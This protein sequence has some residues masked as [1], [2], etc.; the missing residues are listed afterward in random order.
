MARKPPYKHVSFDERPEFLAAVAKLDG[1]DQAEFP[2]LARAQVAKYHDAALIGDVGAL[3][4]ANDAYEALVFALNGG[5]SFGSR[6]DE[7][8]AG[9]VLGRAVAAQPGQVPCWGQAGQFLLEVEGM[10]IWV[11]VQD[12][13]SNHR[14]ITFDA[15]DFDKPFLS[16]SG[17]RWSMLT[18][19]ANVG[20]TVDQAARKEVLSILKAGK[21]HSIKLDWPTE[22]KA[23]NRPAWL[24]E[25]LAAEH[26]DGQLAMF[27]DA[28]PSDKPVPKSNAERQRA[29]RE[30]RKAQQLKPV[31]LDESERQM[32]EELR[33]IGA[34]ANPLDDPRPF[35]LTQRD[36]SYITGALDLY[37]FNT[38][39]HG[40]HN[41]YM[42]DN[43]RD[44]YVRMSVHRVYAQATDF[45]E[46]EK[47][48]GWSIEQTTQTIFD[49]YK[50]KIAALEKENALLE[51]ERNK[52]HGAIALWEQR[53]RSAGLS[54]DY[55][56][57]PGE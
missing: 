49:E 53:L 43:L 54:T 52:A 11:A 36:R 30:R 39:N 21:L 18:A 35:M 20:L 17:H 38:Y 37:E 5:T 28:P 50:K 46:R 44:L 8:S 29:L 15:V 2:A 55:R 23:A 6:A 34:K 16:S 45:P 7:N 56:R 51:S 31:M 42:C 10:R 3:D 14:P 48:Q 33:A 26:A 25:A 22:N 27:G 41:A 1:I 57:Q 4:E 24:A 19:A 47:R 40:G 9:N 12:G 32:L 13:L